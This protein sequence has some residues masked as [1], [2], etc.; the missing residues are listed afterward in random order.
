MIADLTGRTVVIVA[1]APPLGEALVAAFAARGAIVTS[2]E[3]ESFG[4]QLEDLARNGRHLDA[5]VHGAP[6]VPLLA[7]LDDYSEGQLLGAVSRGAWPAVACLLRAKSALGRFPR[8]TVALST[9]VVDRAEPG[10]DFSAAA[11]AVLETLCRYLNPRLA[12][13]RAHFNLIRHRALPAAAAGHPLPDRLTATPRDVANAAVALCSGWMDSMS[14]QVL[15]VDRGAGFCDNVFRL[16]AE[17][18]QPG[19]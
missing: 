4:A 7:G 17:R 2:V 1:V 5:L 8:H 14:G 16:Y 6:E 11:G 18:A 13:E 9:S 19:L 10:A 15:T 12:A 3:E